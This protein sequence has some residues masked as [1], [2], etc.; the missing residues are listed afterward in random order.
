MQSPNGSPYTAQGGYRVPNPGV[1]ISWAEAPG[2]PHLDNPELH[3]AL[4]WRCES[5]TCPSR[6]NEEGR[7]PVPFVGRIEYTDRE[8]GLRLLGTVA[9]AHATMLDAAPLAAMA[10]TTVEDAA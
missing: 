10:M 7:E 8:D 4:F 1:T 6:V 3:G 2:E 5:E 9:V